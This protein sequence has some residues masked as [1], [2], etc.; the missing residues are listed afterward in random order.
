MVLFMRVGITGCTGLIGSVLSEHL[1]ASGHAVTPIVRG[2]AQPGAICWDPAGS[3]IDPSLLL[4]LDAVVHLAGAGIGDRRWTNSYRTM[5]LNS[6]TIGT[7]AI[8][9]AMAAAAPDGGPT[10]LISASA[11]GVYGDAGDTRIDEQSP[12]GLGFLADVCSAWEAATEPATVAGIRVAHIRTG[13]VLSREGGA[14]KKML[15]LF[16]LGLG[17]RF[18]NGRQWQSWISI[19]DHVRAIEHLLSIEVSGPV[20]LTSPNPVTN[21]DFT[22]TLGAVLCRRTLVPVPAFAPKL[23]LGRELAESLLFTG[24]RVYPTVL[25]ESGFR[26]E[27]EELESA[28]RAVLNR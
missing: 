11:V 24:Q 5:I 23:L 27:H 20:N 9:A 25:V 10:I 22:K 28:L 19:L 15:P 3:G 4:G 26:F 7:G 13:I 16:K 12:T 18:G 21:R 2:A 1:K 6:R 17:G 14:L 8:A